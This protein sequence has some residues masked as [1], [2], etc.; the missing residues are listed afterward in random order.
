MSCLRITWWDGVEENTLH[1]EGDLR[2]K[3][4]NLGSTG[5]IAVNLACV[6]IR[7]PS[8][9]CTVPYANDTRTRNRYRK[10]V[11]E[12]LYRF[13]A[14]V[15]CKSVSIFSGTKIWYG[16]LLWYNV[17]LVQETVTKMTSIDWSDD[18]ELC[19]FVYISCVGFIALK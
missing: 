8:V 10:P 7:L 14:G 6:L 12:N 15:S 3:P 17:L 13:S 16:V 11:P 5:K 18:S 19:C 9:Q 2:G 4:S 1:G